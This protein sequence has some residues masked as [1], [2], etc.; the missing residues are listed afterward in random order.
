[1]NH[2]EVG[3]NSADYTLF[4]GQIILFELN[5][6]LTNKDKGYRVMLTPVE[7]D[8]KHQSEENQV[9]TVQIEACE[10]LS[11]SIS[12]LLAGKCKLSEQVSMTQFHK[13]ADSF[14]EM[15]EELN[16]KM[17]RFNELRE[18]LEN[19]TDPEIIEDLKEDILDTMKEMVAIQK[20]I[21]QTAGMSIINIDEM[22]K[23]IAEL[24]S[25]DDL[26][27][28][29]PEEDDDEISIDTERLL[30]TREHVWLGMREAAQCEIGVVVSGNRLAIIMQNSFDPFEFGYREMFSSFNKLNQKIENQVSWLWSVIRQFESTGWIG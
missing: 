18:E 6:K 20:K 21:N 3:R 29:I 30:R 4:Q 17:A 16:Q 19:E 2:E 9:F 15:L 1:M 10:A 11:D 26:D 27:T 14:N 25:I 7:Q 23:K 13:S 22:E 5:R 8:K 28:I 12:E 24:E